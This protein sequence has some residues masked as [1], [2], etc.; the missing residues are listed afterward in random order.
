MI[1]LGMCDAF[2]ITFSWH[3]EKPSVKN[4]NKEKKKR[5]ANETLKNVHT[6]NLRGT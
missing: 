3:V 2:N 6:V 1:C 5:Y 4:L